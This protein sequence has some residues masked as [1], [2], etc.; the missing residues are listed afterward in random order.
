MDIGF[1]QHDLHLREFR[2]EAVA[3]PLIPGCHPA[4]LM[5]IAG[6]AGHQV[7]VSADPGALASE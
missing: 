2:S 6:Q 7:F 3:L 1:L 5:A 4:L